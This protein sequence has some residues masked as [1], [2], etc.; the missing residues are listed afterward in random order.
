MNTKNTVHFDDINAAIEEARQ[1]CQKAGANELDLATFLEILDQDKKPIRIGWELF[2][3]GFKLGA[4][5][6][7]SATPEN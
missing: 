4:E 5:Y 6:Q 1:F 7:K 2:Q 3:I